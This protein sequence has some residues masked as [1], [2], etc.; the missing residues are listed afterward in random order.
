MQDGWSIALF[1]VLYKSLITI[2]LVPFDAVLYLCFK[3]RLTTQGSRSEVFR[4]AKIQV[5]V[6]WVVTLCSVMVGYHR[7]RGPCCFHLQGE[8]SSDGG[9]IW[10]RYRIITSHFNLKTKAAWNSKMVVSYHNT[11]RRH[12]PADLDLNQSINHLSVTSYRPNNWGSIPGRITDPSVLLSIVL[13]LELKRTEHFVLN[14]DQSMFF[15][16]GKRSSFTIT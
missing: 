9:K 15:S 2:F 10:Q 13:F 16:W 8:V 12:N 4:V 6:F 1:L 5:E 14:H 11:T 3:N 7:F